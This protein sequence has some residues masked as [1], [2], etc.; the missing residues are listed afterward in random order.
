MRRISSVLWSF[1][2]CKSNKSFTNIARVSICI[3]NIF[4][5]D[6]VW[7]GYYN[8]YTYN[9]HAM[10]G[11]IISCLCFMF[12]YNWFCRIY[13]A[14]R[15][16]SSSRFDAVFSQ[17]VS[18][19]VADLVLYLEC[20]I[21]SR[22]YIDIIP[23]LLTVGIQLLGSCLIILWVNKTLRS[24]LVPRRILMIHG[25]D[26][27]GWQAEDFASA[28]S[29]M[30]PHLFMF[31]DIV[32]EE[33]KNAVLKALERCDNV[34]FFELSRTARDVYM[35]ICMEHKKTFYFTPFIEDILYQGAEIKYLTDIPILKYKFL[36]DDKT[37][38]FGKRAMDLIIACFMLLLTSPVL[39]FTA[40]AIKLEDGGPVFY[41]QKRYTKG[42]RIFEI[43]KFRS[44][45]TDAEKEG[46][47]PCK[48]NDDR[49][50]RV[51]R[52]IRAM[53]IDELPQLINIL[54][55]DMSFVGPR[56]E[57][58]EHANAYTERMPEFA[59]RLRVK[60]GLTGYAQ[61]WGKYNTSAYDKLRYDLMYIENQSL[62]L[63][64][65]ILI[66]TLRTIFQAE[67]TEGF[68]E[69]ERSYINSITKTAQETCAAVMK[70]EKRIDG[71]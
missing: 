45:V 69:Q 53:R 46:V 13:H 25:K 56:P 21:S 36:N 1:V 59:Y 67:S 61:I 20:C 35:K 62:Y 55:N 34:F 31:A 68:G 2:M 33:D 4:W 43:L 27:E 32:N 26:I 38:Y 29:V 7:I 18:F 52:V 70:T 30:Y 49:I 60:G 19:G 65:K 6:A 58:V 10:Q 22:G 54:K 5:F 12:I 14:F 63:D 11:G 40:L 44:M 51:G 48:D 3:W 23:G 24:R 42:G 47:M 50:T 28:L 16:A 66:L 39:L 15:F 9:T 17:L 8:Q 57:R 37:G 64:F 41:R 71:E